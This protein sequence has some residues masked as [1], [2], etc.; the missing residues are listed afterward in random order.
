MAQNGIST[1]PTKEARQIA[2]LELAQAKRQLV[3]TTGYREL[4]YYDVD[5]LPTHYEGNTVVANPHPNGLV[6]GRPWSTTP[7]GPVVPSATW[8]GIYLEP[9]NEGAQQTIDIFYSNWDNSTIYWTV[10]GGTSSSADFNAVS[11]GLTGLTGSGTAKIHFT[12]VADSTTEG[13]QTYYV[14]V[15][16]TVGGSEIDD[17]GPFTI[18]DTSTSPPAT[19][20]LATAG[21]VT[22]VNEGTALTFNATTT[23]VANGTT[24]Y[25]FIGSTGSYG[26]DAGRYSPGPRGSFTVNS[27]AGTFTV[28]ISADSFTATGTQSY[29]IFLSTTSPSPTGVGNTL[30][31][32]VND[33]STTPPPSPVSFLFNGWDQQIEVQG[34][35]TDWDMVNG[36][37]EFWSKAT[38]ASTGPRAVMTQ[39]PSVGIDIFYEGGYLKVPNGSSGYLQWAE[40]TPGVWTHVAI[41]NLT[42]DTYVF[43]NGVYQGHQMGLDWANTSAT[44]YIGRRQGN[45]QYFDGKLYGIRI[46]QS[47]LY[48]DPYNIVNFDPYTVALPPA[49]VSYTTLLMNPTDQLTLSDLS[50]S[51]HTLNASVGNAADQPALTGFHTYTAATSYNGTTP[52]SVY[53]PIADYPALASVPSSGATMTSAIFADPNSPVTITSSAPWAFNPS[54]W[55]IGYANP[56]GTIPGTTRNT[57]PGD[58]FTITW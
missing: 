18:N 58:T 42:G 33:T 1:L 24:L 51:H 10:Y 4:R 55:R 3:D 26:I 28:T 14:K 53:I 22:S 34:S 47:N 54:V 45:F 41:V 29:N 44:L 11:G 13:S 8:G 37:I 50:D 17:Q 20:S 43:Y 32:T 16:T 38:A 46:V 15:G 40:P 23:N 19:Y 7:T 48:V 30:S 35:T 56:G 27:N 25:W 9:I 39:Q 57:V 36:T 5:L 31:I 12:P 52:G 2:K 6:Q 21:S 49:K